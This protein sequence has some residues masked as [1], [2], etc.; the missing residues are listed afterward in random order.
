MSQISANELENPAETPAYPPVSAEE[1]EV[2]NILLVDDRPDKLAA[3]ASL[4][5]D[6]SLKLVPV[7]SGAEALRHLL[8]EDFALILLDVN[9]PGMDGFET[10][11]LIRQRKRTEHTP[12][13]F[14]T[15]Y[16]AD[17]SRLAR[18]YS[19][20]A[21][22]FIFAPALPATL[23]AKV[24][25]LVDLYRINRTVRRQA[26]S[27]AAKRIELAASNEKLE[28]KVKERTAELEAMNQSLQKEI[29]DRKAAEEGLKA[30][31]GEK[32]ALLKEIHHRVKNNLQIISS[33][34]RLQSGRSKDPLVLG[35]LKDSQ[36][37]LKSMVMVHEK[38]Y[39]SS[40]LAQISLAEY[41]GDLTRHLSR[42]FD[43]EERGIALELEMA[44][45]AVNA[46][47]ALPCGLVVHEL[48]SNALKHG[49]PPERLNRAGPSPKVTV[50][51][52]RH[53]DGEY[54][55]EVADNGIGLP[56]DLDLLHTQSL[57]MQ[58][59][60]VLV[61]QLGGQLTIERDGGTAFRILLAAD[62]LQGRL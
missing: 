47:L 38:L 32:E 42:S 37:R 41:L 44:D 51:S 21:V 29:Q 45:L 58:L 14:V 59:V 20:G 62:H 40:N 43:A 31:L 52:R 9:M 35:L 3:L 46:D 5:S 56:A 11:A 17:D 16:Y 49:F 18:G 10:A 54:R 25:V 61:K 26:E 15:A 13:I 4:L 12:I 28:I 2:A 7:A 50:R 24:D 30:S 53:P 6:A 36:N 23:K 48:V 8:R 60:L 34:L 27:L 22:D 33:L 39:S 1:K 19:L 55:I 57:G